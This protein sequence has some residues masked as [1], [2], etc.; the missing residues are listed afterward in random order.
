MILMT[1]TVPIRGMHLRPDQ[2]AGPAATSFMT[3][4][5]AGLAG[6]MNSNSGLNAEVASV[7]AASAPDTGPPMSTCRDAHHGNP[8]RTPRLL[9]GPPPRPNVRL[10]LMIMHRSIRVRMCPVERWVPLSVPPRFL[11]FVPGNC[12]ASEK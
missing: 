7:R 1:A 6:P 11:Y 5:G 4:A 8:G 12:P 10:P 3:L 9:P 2:A